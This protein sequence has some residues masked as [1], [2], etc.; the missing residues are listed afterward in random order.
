MGRHCAPDIANRLRAMGATLWPIEGLLRFLRTPRWWLRPLAAM[1]VGWLVL[2]SLAILAG[3]WAW[4]V[5]T[6][7][8]LWYA[9]AVAKAV[10]VGF[11]TLLLAWALLLPL[12]MSFAFEAL[13][14]LAQRADGAAPTMELGLHA[15]IGGSLRVL[16]GTL[17]PRLLW[18]LSGFALSLAVGPIGIVVSVIGLAHIAAIDSLDLAM[19]VRGLSGS[20]RLVALRAHRGELWQGTLVAALLNFGL[21]A[22]VIAWILWLP[23]LAVGAARLVLGWSEVLAHSAPVPGTSQVIAAADALPAGT[24]ATPPA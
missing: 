13:V 7:K 15:G 8:G 11:A 2:L 21:G 4:P 17:L 24:G 14:R 6:V 22:M 12:L 1:A 10:G 20:D 5:A 16:A 18:P 23:G 19:A 3:W 9:L